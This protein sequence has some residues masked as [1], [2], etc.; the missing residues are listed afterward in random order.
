M[1]HFNALMNLKILIFGTAPAAKQNSSA[2]PR[3]SGDFQF[4]LT[5]YT[6]S[7]KK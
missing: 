4:K 3:Q 2:S 1:A 7:T 6:A 5:Q